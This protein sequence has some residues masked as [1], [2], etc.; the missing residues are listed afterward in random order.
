[1]SVRIL[2]VDDSPVFLASIRQYLTLLPQAQVVDEAIN[3]QQALAHAAALKPNLVL[4]DIAL[5]DISGLD[6]A[7]TMKTWPHSPKVLFLSMHDNESYRQAAQEL[8]A[9]AFV[10][11]ANFVTELPT[12][13]ESLAAGQPAVNMGP[14]T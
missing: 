8:G 6:V 2:L 3:G 13:I 4:L 1:M 10:N 12:L 14:G 9:V 5:P 7:R 11:K